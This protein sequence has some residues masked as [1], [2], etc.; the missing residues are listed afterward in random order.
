VADRFHLLQNLGQALDRLLTR[1]HRVF[2]QF[3][4]AVAQAA[5]EVAAADRTATTLALPGLTLSACV[6]RLVSLV[7]TTCR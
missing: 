3:A 6:G 7:G 1:E 2:T 5:E 4:D